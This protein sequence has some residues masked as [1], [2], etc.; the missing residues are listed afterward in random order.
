MRCE[1]DNTLLGCVLKI[2][3]HSNS[4]AINSVYRHLGEVVAG[5]FFWRR[6]AK[7]WTLSKNM[8][9]KTDLAYNWAGFRCR[10]CFKWYILIVYNTM[11]V[12]CMFSQDQVLLNFS[13]HSLF[14]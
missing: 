13:P 2:L 7:Y 5:A 8:L 3:M 6:H 12:G 1:I 10:C 14:G 11:C 4:T 9:N